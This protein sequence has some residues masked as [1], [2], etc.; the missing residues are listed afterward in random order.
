VFIAKKMFLTKGVGTHRSELASVRIALRDAGIAHYN[1][2]LISDVLPG[3]CELIPRDQGI[4][5][6]HPGEIVFCALTKNTT[7]KPRQRVT[8]AVGVAIPTDQDN[9]GCVFGHHSCCETSRT[10]SQRVEE[11]VTE[12]IV[13]SGGMQLTGIDTKRIT[14]E[15]PDEV[16]VTSIAASTINGSNGLWSAVVAGVVFIQ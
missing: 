6:L 15:V 5:Y 4:E 8:A 3:R 12:R 11:V 14:C 7:D 1:L 16:T 2:V 9:F 13:S 10:A